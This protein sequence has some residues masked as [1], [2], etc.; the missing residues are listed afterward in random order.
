[1]LKSNTI[2]WFFVIG[3]GWT[4]ALM[5]N[6]I[7]SP[8]G[9]GIRQLSW[10]SDIQRSV[11]LRDLGIAEPVILAGTAN[12]DFYI[13]V[14]HGIP[15]GDANIEF[16][17]RYL[18]GVPGSATL[19]LSVNGIPANARAIPDGDGVLQSTLPV[20][21][22]STLSNFVRLGVNWRMH[23]GEQRCDESSSQ[24]NSITVSPKTR[25][26][27]RVDAKNLRTVDDVWGALP[28]HVSILVSAKQLDKTSFDSA[29]RI[30]TALLRS[31]KKITV[32]SMPAVG[33][34]IDAKDLTIP[35]AFA[36]NPVFSNLKSSDSAIKITSNAQLGALLVLGAAQTSGDIVL[37]DAVMQQQLSAAMDA[38]QVQLSSDPDASDALKIWREKQLPLAKESMPSKGISVMPMGRQRVLSVAADAGAQLSGLQETGLQKLLV[39]A[40]VNVQAA[41]PARWDDAKGI[42]LTNLGGSEGSFDVVSKGDWSINFPL[43]AVASQGK[44]PSELTLYVSAAPGAS[45]TRPVASVFWNGVLLSAKQLEAGGSPEQLTARIPSYA[46]GVN[47]NLRVSVQRQP[48]SADCNEVP[49][50]YPASVYPAIS[51]VSPGSAHPDGTFIGLLPLLGTQSQLLV[52]EAYLKAAPT[53]LERIASIASAAGISASQAELIVSKA[54]ASSKPSKPFLSMDVAL[55]DAKPQVFVTN[56][57]QLQIR[58]KDLAW[59]DIS[60]L[61]QISSAEVVKSSGQHG[62]LWHAIGNFDSGINDSF[63]LNRGNIAV[64][65]SDGP[66]AWVD[67]SNPDEGISPNVRKTP[68]YEWRNFVSWG[69]PGVVIAVLLLLLLF[70]MAWRIAHKGQIKK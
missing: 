56:G 8:L 12:H 65:G 10:G 4:P 2:R 40:S 32:R 41:Q 21:K 46:L 63:L 42:R 67:S 48:Y 13:P 61:H 23:I 44:V 55:E 47:N 14:P 57:K 11:T 33:E 9:D 62:I 36:S 69:V 66:V 34:S 31:G 24:A 64:I 38:L 29:W 50:A 20:N 28:A 25:L 22:T 60:G 30:G 68:F 26:N 70:W 58:G 5:Q 45:S 59:L 51:Y 6:V 39:S 7:A 43:S 27:Y 53:N 35:A 15:L 37:S 1:M 16:D 3:L 18:K 19:V 17:G 52:P 54:G 49:Q